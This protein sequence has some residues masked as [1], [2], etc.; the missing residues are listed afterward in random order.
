M[1]AILQWLYLWMLAPLALYIGGESS[2]SSS[3]SNSTTTQNTDRRQVVD[4]GGV[5]ISSDTSTVSVTLTDR[6]AVKQAIDLSKTSSELAY[7]NLSALLGFA[8]DG[9]ALADKNAGAVADAFK[10]ASEISSGQKMLV[11][12]G[13]LIAGIVAI[14]SFKG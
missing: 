11:T 14:K 6:D 2:S 3:S 13:L 4:N 5:G 9:L 8:K 12:G 1:R 10:T 7:Q